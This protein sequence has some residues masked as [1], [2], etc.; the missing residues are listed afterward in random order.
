MGR[1]VCAHYGFPPSYY[2]RKGEVLKVAGL[3]PEPVCGQTVQTPRC[4]A[5]ARASFRECKVDLESLFYKGTEHK[6]E[7]QTTMPFNRGML[8]IFYY[9]VRKRRSSCLVLPDSWHPGG[10]PGLALFSLIESGLGFGLQAEASETSRDYF[11][12][13]DLDDI[14]A[15]A[16]ERIRRKKNKILCS[17]PV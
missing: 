6:K 13:I 12:F 1:C 2:A 4:V 15:Q 11:Y 16:P 10:T 17:I 3:S 5:F 14:S 7:T 8:Q 9:D